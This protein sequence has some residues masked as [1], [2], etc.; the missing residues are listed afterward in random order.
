M[1]AACAQGILAAGVEEEASSRWVSGVHSNRLAGSGKPA[2]GTCSGR[3]DRPGAGP[4]AAR[5]MAKARSQEAVLLT[6][7][8]NGAML[9]SHPILECDYIG[10]GPCHVWAFAN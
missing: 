7:Q 1:G 6:T 3:G 5:A 9:W 10:E 8:G 4:S 2:E